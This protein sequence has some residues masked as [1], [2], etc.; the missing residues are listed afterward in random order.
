MVKV[1]K[2]NISLLCGL[3]KGTKV[4]KNF[5][6]FLHSSMNALLIVVLVFFYYYYLCAIVY[7]D[8]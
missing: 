2:N 3:R 5:T 7:E 4:K 1:D 8:L 6:F